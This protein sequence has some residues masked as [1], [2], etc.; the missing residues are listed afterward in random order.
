MINGLALL[1]IQ[2][3]VIT[4]KK[5]TLGGKITCVQF[6]HTLP[7]TKT[8]ATTSPL[9]ITNATALLIFIVDL[10]FALVLALVLILVLALVLVLILI[11]ILIL[12]LHHKNT[13]FFEVML[14]C[15]GEIV[16]IHSY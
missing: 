14:V 11:L 4:V 3:T 16:S 10:V 15:D 5:C 2:I 1:F 8:G 12:V 9:S 7:F 6:T 13:P